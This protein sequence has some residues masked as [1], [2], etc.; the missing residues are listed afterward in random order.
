LTAIQRLICEMKDLAHTLLH[1][2]TDSSVTYYVR[3][4]ASVRSKDVG[5]QCPYCRLLVMMVEGR[6]QQNV[7]GEGQRHELRQR[8][9]IRP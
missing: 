2:P 8:I 5:V 4:M 7:S 1:R 9:A 3:A 6:V